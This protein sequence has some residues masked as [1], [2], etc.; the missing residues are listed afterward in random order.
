MFMQGDIL[1][2]G[3]NYFKPTLET[4]VVKV[5]IIERELTRMSRSKA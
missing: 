5:I 1:F 2:K 4:C 3:S